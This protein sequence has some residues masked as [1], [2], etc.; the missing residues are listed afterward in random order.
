MTV[1][2]RR[3]RE[4]IENACGPC[5]CPQLAELKGLFENVS[6]LEKACDKYVH[7]GAVAHVDNPADAEFADPAFTQAYAD[8]HTRWEK[9]KETYHNYALPNHAVKGDLLFKLHDAEKQ[10]IVRTMP[11]TEVQRE[12]HITR[13]DCAPFITINCARCERY[14]G[15]AV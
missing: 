4:D 10:R 2:G 13:N 14:W 3:Y 8:T 7:E 5:D 9:V 12:L 15:V 6:A 11:Y 1:A